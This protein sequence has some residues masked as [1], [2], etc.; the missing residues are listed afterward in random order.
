ML[1]IEVFDKKIMIVR[2]D[3]YPTSD[4]IASN[5]IIVRSISC[6]EAKYDWEDDLVIIFLRGAHKRD[7]NAPLLMKTPNDMLRAISA[8]GEYCQSVGETF[9]LNGRTCLSYA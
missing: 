4:F 8:L 2:Q 7:D 9:V 6:P 3:N 1:Q 5:R